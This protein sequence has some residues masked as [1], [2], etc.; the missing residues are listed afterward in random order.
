MTGTSIRTFLI[1]DVRGYT[2]FTAERGDEAAAALA[3]RFATIAR[4]A[5]AARSGDVI[6][7]RGDEALA[8]FSS[9]RQALWAAAELQDR[10]ATAML[11]DPSL[12]LRAGIGLDAGEAI[13]ME[14]GFR[15]AALNRAARL[16]SLAGAGEVLTS[17][18]VLHL[19]GKI[20]GLAYVERGSAE[21]KGFAEPVRVYGV[22]PEGVEEGKAPSLED[23]A[24]PMPAAPEQHLP[25]G[26]F[27]G[28]LPAGLLV[29]R[30]RELEQG[31]AGIDAVQQGE[32]RLLLLAGEPGV[33]KTRLAQEIT[34]ELRNR[35]F[36]IAAGSC[37]EA[38]E[39]SAY[40]PLL[41]ALATLYSLAPA[42]LRAQIP[43]RFPYLA[44]LLPG[45]SLPVPPSPSGDGSQ[46]RLLWSVS[47]FLSALA[48]H[49]P[50]ALL[51]DDLHWA[52][53]SSLELLRHVAHQTRR[54]RLLILG[55]YRDVE[56][57]R[58]HPG[59]G[60]PGL[61]QTLH[62]LDRQGLI[63]RV[64]VRR[65]A[66]DGATALV[67]ASFDE[68]QISDDF[69]D[70]LYERT[71]GNPFFLQQVLRDLVE[72]GDLY[73][74]DGR[75]ERKSIDELSV[76]ESI[77]SAVGQRL[78]RL[79]DETQEVLQQASVLGGNFAFDELL[80]LA[81]LDEERLESCLDEAAGA[82]LVGTQDGEVYGFDHALTRQALYAEL[83][84]R[85]RRRLHRAAGEAMEQLP[86]KRR[87]ARL[88]EL[89]WH[90]VQADEREKALQ[91]SLQAG[92][93]ARAIYA[94]A[95]AEMHYRT[96]VELA[97]E[98]DDRGL[99]MEAREKLGGT[100]ARTARYDEALEA[101]E[102]ALRFH[103]E[104]GDFEGEVR[105]LAD[106]GGILMDQNQRD[107]GIERLRPVMERWERDPLVSADA[108]RFHLALAN[109]YWHAGSGEDQLRLLDRAVELAKAVGDDRLLGR[110][111]NT[112]GTVL[113]ESGRTDEALDAYT[114]SI[115]LLDAAGDLLSLGR[116]LNNR[117]YIYGVH[118]ESDKAFA[119][120]ERALA[121]ARQVGDPTQLGW[122]LGIL[123]WTWWS[124]GGDWNRAHPH[125]E[126]L[127]GM[128]HRVRGTRTSEFLP[129]AIWL[130]LVAGSD[131]S[132]L[133][134]LERL[135][136]EGERDGDVNLWQYAQYW[137]AQWDAVHGRTSE[138]LARYD[139]VLAHPGIESQSRP[140]FERHLAY[141]CV[142][143]GELERAGSLI[144]EHP[145]T[146]TSL[147]WV[148]PWPTWLAVRARLRAAQGKW[149][150]A[151]ADFEGA[152]GYSRERSLALGI[153]ET[154]HAYGEMLA[155]RGEIGAARERFAEALSVFRR[156]SAQPYTAQTE[157]ALAELK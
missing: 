17:D 81:Q 84:P 134:D 133:Q 74:E 92:D 88:G 21:L 4:E 69:A 44:A 78:G 37:Y 3:V 64:A 1:A 145:Q 18:G 126:E 90:F 156:M 95:D 24:I 154:A 27:L 67:A 53:S 76:P 118:G 72:R 15:G 29:G 2:R 149:E 50:V 106:V 83:S 114:R 140:I 130:R 39:T 31:L 80:E 135:A 151:R 66:K 97:K 23:S 98:I 143:C 28:S 131:N 124:A 71:E 146:E 73:Q 87:Q 96:A 52:D 157:R 79:S 54:D 42:S 127:L 122:A 137:L 93:A 86:G 138:A 155:Q 19:A 20:D 47:G 99:E 41:E 32:G 25:I 14:G 68:E 75:W 139:A 123:A 8:V 62:E 132:A 7:L 6:E 33:G 40:F 58:Q 56:V 46:D 13:P 119:D 108:A 144:S 70:L 147:T 12:P 61:Q 115:P 105:I 129:L 121:L 10:F 49:A 63:E 128:E 152:L 148:F 82:G 38:R 150:E 91:Y 142:V 136:D 48:T 110:L 65:L 35:G 117:A 22:Q 36:L 112:Q 11:D 116:S 109:L 141:L 104:R 51:L 94:H 9:T 125:A 34:L 26:G 30:E 57:G 59:H 107:E 45:E 102:A 16:C 100:L 85:K 55:T 153:G 120:L 5:V 89:A 60:G 101:Y 113:S 111:E 77:R 43:Q 103:R